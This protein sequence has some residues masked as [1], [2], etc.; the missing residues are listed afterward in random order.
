MKGKKSKPSKKLFNRYTALGVIL[1]LLISGLASKLIVLQVVNAQ[2][3]EETA[4]NK[5]HKLISEPAS[6]GVIVDKNGTELATN[7]PS[8]MLVFTETEDSD[9][10]FFETMPQVFKILD[11]N[12]ESQVDDFELKINPFRFE[13]K[14]D[15]PAV[16]KNWELRFKKDR[17][18]D[19]EIVRK[20]Y[21]GKTAS[22]L[23]DAQKKVV[24]D[25]LLKLTPEETYNRL[26]TQYGL[27]G[28]DSSGK[29]VG[30]DLT[31]KYSPEEVRR[32]L[33]IKDAV[34]MESFSGYK[35]VTIAA[36][37]KQSTAFIFLQKL[38]SLPGID[39]QVQPIRNYPLGT[40]ASN[41]LGY[42]SKINPSQQEKYEEKGYDV[43]T[44]YVGTS[45]IEAAFEDRL[46]GAKGGKIVEV[47]KSG[48]TINELAQKLPAQGQ[49]I[50]L[51]IDKD[52]Q[53][54]AE[55]A[56]D[57]T[58]ASLRAQGITHDDGGSNNMTNATRGAAV[59]ID[60]KTGAV[61]A[62]ASRPGFNPNDF[63][64]PRGL[65]SD[66]IT[67]YFN[68][69]YEAFGKS[70]GYDQQ[71]INELFPVDTSIQ[72]NT[73]IRKDKYDLI[74]KPLYNYATFSLTPPGSTFKPLT[75]IAGLESGVVTK[76]TTVDDEGFFNDGKGF[77]T[78]FKSDGVHGVVNLVSAIGVSSN[79]YFMRVGQ[80][81][82]S[83]YG[84]DKLADYAWK[85]GLGVKPNSGV[86]PSTGIEIPEN[87][88]QVFNS[89]SAKNMYATQYLYATMEALK[90]GKEPN[91]GAS[92]T[93]IDLYEHDS[94]SSDV[95][96]LKSQIKDMVRSSIKDGN[97]DKDK[98]QY[99]TLI[100]NLIKA[101]PQYSGKNIGDTQINN[102][103]QLI[104]N[105][106]ISTGHY[107][108]NMG[109]NIYNA[110]IGQGMDQF[111]PLQL[112]NYIAT[113]VNGGNRYKVHLVD[114]I[115]DADGKNVLVDNSKPEIVEQTGISQATIEAV[116]EG[117]HE[118]VN[119]QDGT[120]NKV[121]QG[122]PIDTA[123]KTG[124][125]TY[126]SKEIQDSV[127]RSSFGVY[128]G[129][130]PYDNPQ[131]AVAVVIFDAAY[132]ANAAPV[133]KA[134]Y[135]AYFQDELKTKYNYQLPDYVTA[136]TEN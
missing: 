72:G 119:S 33:V 95:K 8:Y 91:K 124:T 102:I 81:L 111:T 96:S 18:L 44:D 114:K 58:M 5:S 10:S 1:M 135:E 48:R 128:V 13:F 29:V 27:T 53:Y 51:T 97:F 113:I 15:D 25:E 77:K 47:N 83:Q 80:L 117:M 64:D 17:G 50:Q 30:E 118:V 14:S 11:D 16:R 125:A 120:A 7:V 23:T 133:A 34:K 105:V 84:D 12:G 126:S 37:I 127:G 63:A 109:T 36:N 43:S 112:A 56:L 4:N 57:R 21:K 75:A 110:S 87:F 116:K 9:K 39:V 88:G 123:G 49:K 20:L 78:E 99:K 41:V 103:L 100:T 79:P 122:F 71:R 60:V 130:A 55:Q 54:A 62:L 67:K 104:Y 66:E 61:L 98:A 2:Q 136:Q 89:W 101:D 68:P 107:Q 69:D 106:A 74:A 6:R 35:P 31:K 85:F 45:G 86:K 115:Y 129:F 93:P 70:K 82:R 132:G 26:L 19:E 108:T 134:M 92:C 52:V 73:T 22:E 76:D 65:T 131:I 94:D 90:N 38:S 59:C 42:I 32:L 46:K 28:K 40:L 24:D 3:Y 121:F